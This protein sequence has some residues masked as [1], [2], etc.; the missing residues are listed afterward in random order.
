MAKKRIIFHDE[1]DIF[2]QAYFLLDKLGDYEEKELMKQF[3]EILE[4][5]DKA[6]LFN[7]LEELSLHKLPI[8]MHNDILSLKQQLK[9]HLIL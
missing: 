4:S 6:K 9:E 2:D 5:Q 8:E 7:F 1:L 3:E